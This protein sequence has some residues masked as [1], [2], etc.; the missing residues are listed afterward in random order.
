M[1]E[2]E[3]DQVTSEHIQ[4]YADKNKMSYDQALAHLLA[5]GMKS[6]GSAEDFF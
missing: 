6:S 3:G 4:I 5:N 1:Y 2:Y